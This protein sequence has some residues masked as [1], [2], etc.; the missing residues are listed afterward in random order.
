MSK[1]DSKRARRAGPTGAP[2]RLPAQ[3]RGKTKNKNGQIAYYRSKGISDDTIK[4]MLGLEKLP[5]RKPG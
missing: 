4:L 3:S 2:R 1:R 5:K